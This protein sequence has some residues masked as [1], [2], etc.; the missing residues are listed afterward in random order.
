MPLEGFFFRRRVRR[1][2][3][4]RRISFLNCIWK[5]AWKGGTWRELEGR[6]WR[7]LEG[8]S[9]KKLEDRRW[10]ELKGRSWKET[11]RQEGAG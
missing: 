11:E 8:R 5:N 10:K 3:I 4:V 1:G 7:E 6:S 2:S 9:W